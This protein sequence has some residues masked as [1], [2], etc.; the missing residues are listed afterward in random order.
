MASVPLLRARAK[1]TSIHS[2][3]S[4]HAEKFSSGRFIASSV[5]IGITSSQRLNAVPTARSVQPNFRIGPLA[6]PASLRA[7]WGRDRNPRTPKGRRYPFHRQDCN[8]AVG[9][10]AGSRRF[11]PDAPELSPATADRKGWVHEKKL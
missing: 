3:K 6:N 10:D 5:V 11:G 7:R 8:R 4:A 2:L 9:T 1:A